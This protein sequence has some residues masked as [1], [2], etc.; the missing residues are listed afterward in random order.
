M[1]TKLA[2]LFLL[3]LCSRLEAK[4]YDE[5]MAKK[6]LPLASAAYT[7]DPVPCIKTAY[8]NAELVE[9]YETICDNTNLD[10]CSG[11]LALIP[12]GEGN[13]CC[14][15]VSFDLEQIAAILPKKNFENLGKVNQYFYDAFWALWKAGMGKK[16]DD[17]VSNS[18]YQNYNL[19][20]TGHSLGWYLDT[21]ICLK[22]HLGAAISSLA[23]VKIINDYPQR[24]NM[25]NS[26]HYNYGFVFKIMQIDVKAM[27][28]QPRIG[29]KQFSTSHVNKIPDFW[30]LTHRSDLVTMLPEMKY[31]FIHFQREVWYNNTM[32]KGSAYIFC[33]I[34]NDPKCSGPPRLDWEDHR[35]YFG[36]KVP[37]DAS[38][39][40]CSVAL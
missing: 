10:T 2:C 4:P 20:V 40:G 30:R 9:R 14:F 33:E 36:I 3:A 6:I 21:N 31:G 39:N 35:H 27:F 26:Y 25:D 1:L 16:F 13:C 29:D 22:L 17:L 15:S 23:S 12:F 18:K 38:A 8:S 11:Y 5:T 7:D 37:E 28:R 34:E 32:S 19:W 24:F